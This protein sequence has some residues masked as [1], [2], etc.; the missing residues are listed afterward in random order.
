[1]NEREKIHNATLKALEQDK[2]KNKKVRLVENDV[3]LSAE[4]I[5]LLRDMYISI[6]NAETCIGITDSDM[7]RISNRLVEIITEALLNFLN[8]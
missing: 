8:N 6:L 2:R 5:D 3:L 1:M 7:Q 4:Q